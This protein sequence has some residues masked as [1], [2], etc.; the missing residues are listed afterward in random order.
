[1]VCPGAPLASL[2]LRVFM[3]EFLYL[4]AS[5]APGEN[6]PTPAVYPASGFSALPLRLG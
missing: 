4:P 2:E 6:S 3:E 1:V 5:I